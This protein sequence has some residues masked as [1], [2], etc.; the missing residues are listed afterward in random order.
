MR[1]RIVQLCAVLPIV[2]AASLT[3]AQTR[4]SRRHQHP[5][6]TA[7]QHL[8]AKPE[9]PPLPCGDHLGFQVLLDR[10]GFSPGEIDGVPG[11]NLSHALAAV[12]AVRALPVT[13]EP[14][15]D[16]WHALEGD[17]SGALVASYTISDEDVAGPFT[18]AIPSDL[19]QQARLPALGY[20]SALERLGEKFHASTRLLRRLNPGLRIAAGTTIHVPA[21]EPFDASARPLPVADSDV[22]IVVSTEDSS[23]RALG[24]DGALVFFA[25]VTTGSTHDPLPIGDWKVTGVR[26]YPPF[27]YSPTLFWDAK[28]Q[29]T[30]ATIKPGPNNPVGVVWIDL[31]RPHYGLHGTPEPGSIGRTA[32]HGC[33]RLTN[34]DAARVTALVKPGTPVHFR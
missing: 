18:E 2:C 8:S 7:A 15:C 31:D 32:S 5:P 3:A 13:G 29:D 25:P 26:W 9:P 24:S 30:R 28:P 10:Q 19:M 17:Q 11:S 12:Q 34:W 21:T 23:L 27:H 33:V 20:R 4:P 14:D 22:S 16:T 6:R 1:A